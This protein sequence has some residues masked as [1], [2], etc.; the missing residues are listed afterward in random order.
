MDQIQFDRPEKVRT[1]I[2]LL[3][4]TLGIGVLRFFFEGSAF[5][6]MSTPGH[7]MF[8]GLFVIGS[9]LFFI[10]KIG[11]GRN[12]A[13]ITFSV[14]FILGIP[15]SVSPLIKSLSDYPISGLLGIIQA[16]LQGIAI[17]F[18]FQKPSSDWFKDM[19]IR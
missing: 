6:K 7:M 2:Q 17:V 4:S 9:M 16:V 15:L 3:Y 11:K 14:M 8:L 12:W 19:K 18:L 10:Y 13:R 5:I 1:A